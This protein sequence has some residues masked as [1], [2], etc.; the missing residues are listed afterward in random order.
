[1]WHGCYPGYYYF[2]VFSFF[3]NFIGAYF[4]KRLTPIIPKNPV[5]QFI[6][7]AFC[8]VISMSGLNYGACCFV[9]LSHEYSMNALRN[10]HYIGIIV[11]AILFVYAVVDPIRPKTKKH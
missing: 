2:F 6:Y 7:A 8:F 5:V 3:T 4:A 9:A 10:T 1:M 11:A